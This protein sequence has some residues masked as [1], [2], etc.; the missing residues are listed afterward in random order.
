MYSSDPR[1]DT[2]SLMQFE[3]RRAAHVGLTAL[4]IQSLSQEILIIPQLDGRD[5]KNRYRLRDHAHFFHFLVFSIANYEAD[6]RSAALLLRIKALALQERPLFA[7]VALVGRKAHDRRHLGCRN[8]MRSRRCAL[9]SK[10][11][12]LN[13]ASNIG[14]S[15]FL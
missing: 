15:H 8:V 2:G 5:V 4:M 6:S 3:S 13:I 7:L 1:P 12:T 9:Q 10:R 11:I 14:V